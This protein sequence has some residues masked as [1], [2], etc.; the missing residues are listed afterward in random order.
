MAGQEIIQTFRQRIEKTIEDLRRELA[1]IRTGRANAGM[2]D[3]VF[4]ESY[5]SRMPLN[6]V[7]SI[8]VPDA[9]TLM[10]KPFDKS[11]ISAIERAILESDVGITPQNDGTVIR[12][13][14]PALTEE[15]RKEIAKQV[16]KKG[17]DYKISIR[18]AR[19]DSNE[20]VKSLTKEG[21][22]SDDEE[23]RLLDQVQKETDAGIAKLDEVVARKEKEV[24]EI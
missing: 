11:Q 4:V 16:R 18:N 6:A 12:L 1:K 3:G 7:S 2:L 5:G 15:R 19:R 10:I 14:I 20:Q 17:E 21:E 22:I 23:K 24:M 9:R 13:P 8:T